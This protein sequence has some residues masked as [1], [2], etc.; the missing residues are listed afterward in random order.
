M[1][2]TLVIAK[3]GE[4]SDYKFKDQHLSS[5]QKCLK[6]QKRTYLIIKINN[7]KLVVTK[8]QYTIALLN[9]GCER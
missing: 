2:F 9:L 4:F 5:R 6:Y 7:C 3:L 8:I 1:E